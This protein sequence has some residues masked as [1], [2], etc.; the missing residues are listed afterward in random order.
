MNRT[1]QILD[2]LTDERSYTIDEISRYFDIPQDISKKIVNFLAKYGFILIKDF[3]VKINPKA[4]NFIT[5]TSAKA[6]FQPAMPVTQQAK[7]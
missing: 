5:L 2:L 4:K 7:L 1:D 6:I 3:K